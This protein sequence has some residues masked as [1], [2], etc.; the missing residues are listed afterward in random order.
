MRTRTFIAGMIALPLNAVLFGAGAI[1]V[2]SIPAL[3]QNAVYLLPAVIIAGFILT[4]PLAWMLAPRLR[5]RKL[6]ADQGTNG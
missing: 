4:A 1:T 3:S 2:L 5:A 6:Y